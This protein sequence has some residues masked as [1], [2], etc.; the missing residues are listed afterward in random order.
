LVSVSD[1]EIKS[2]IKEHKQILKRESRN[3]QYVSFDETPTEDDLSTIRLRLEGLKN[4]RIAYNDVSK[5][6]DTLEG[7]KKRLKIF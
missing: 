4:E 1:A 7:F 6:T 5:L 2:Y 3:I